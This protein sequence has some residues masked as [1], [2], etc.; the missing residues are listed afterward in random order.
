MKQAT[1]HH[2]RVTRRKF[3]ADCAMLLAGVALGAA[4][5]L[6]AQTAPA[7]AGP[8]SPQLIEDLVAAY[9]VLADHGVL[10]AYGHV[11]A[12]HDRDPN[13]YLLSFSRGPELVTADDIMEYDL[14][15]N[16]V[17]DKG[18]TLRRERFIHGEIYKVRPDVTAIVHCHTPSLIPFG[19]S[20]VP[21]RPVYHMAAFLW[22]GVPVFEIREAEER[23]MTNMLV[24]SPMLG[25]ALAQTL[26]SKPAA[27][28]RGHGA[29][30]VGPSIRMAV[31]RS[32]YMSINAKLQNQA[33]SLGGNVTYIDP[34]EGRLTTLDEY[35]RGWE[36]W[37]RKAMT[38]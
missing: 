24:G 18:R 5:R 14:D 7:S 6:G 36:T 17:D 25:R 29:V 33:I 38:K 23:K 27:L 4:S 13:R 20:T 2:R 15:N 1:L 11:S 21:L 32:I 22:E 34:E 35:R 37:K 31:G 3:A 28:M 26:G 12:R 16:P 8:A 19:I 9:R 10:D 30:V